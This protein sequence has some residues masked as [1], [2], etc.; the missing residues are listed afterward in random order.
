LK[1]DPPEI[2]GI[3]LLK[4]LKD[5][6]NW[7]VL[8]LNKRLSFYFLNIHNV[9]NCLK[10]FMKMKRI[11]TNMKNNDKRVLNLLN[12]NML[13]LL[14]KKSLMDLKSGVEKW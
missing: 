12:P 14:K 10:R 8:R 3:D 9:N 1:L 6:F 5:F 11:K 2:F 13:E 4:P 7:M